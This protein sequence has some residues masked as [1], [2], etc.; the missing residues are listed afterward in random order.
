MTGAEVTEA[1]AGEKR[2]CF[3]RRQRVPDITEHGK[4]SVFT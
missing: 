3:D 1:D 4:G 2:V